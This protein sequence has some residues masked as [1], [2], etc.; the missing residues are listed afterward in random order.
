MKQTFEEFMQEVHFQTHPQLLDDDI[1]DSYDAWIG[2]Q[3][4]EEMMDWAQL[5]G[6]QCWLNG[7]E[8][9][10]A[11]IQKDNKNNI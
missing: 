5:Y 8:E 3:D 6:R 11:N 1:P 7:K 9:V 4:I 2:N 10:L